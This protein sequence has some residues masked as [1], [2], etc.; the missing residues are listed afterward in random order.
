MWPFADQRGVKSFQNA[1]CLYTLG[2]L[3]LISMKPTIQA[4]ADAH[5]T[6]DQANICI[7]GAKKASNT[8]L[9]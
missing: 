7:A 9:I 1:L 5:P 6:F 4:G 8:L 3:A 2:L